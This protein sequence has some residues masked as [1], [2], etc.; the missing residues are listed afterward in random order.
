[1]STT[2]LCCFSF[3][4]IVTAI[5]QDHSENTTQLNWDFLDG[6]DD[7]E[8]RKN[9]A[10]D[11]DNGG[12]AVSSGQGGGDVGSNNLTKYL[13]PNPSQSKS[14]PDSNSNGTAATSS[15]GREDGSPTF[16]LDAADDNTSSPAPHQSATPSPTTL[17]NYQTTPS[18]PSHFTTTP[19]AYSGQHPTPVVA[20][21]FPNHPNITQIPPNQHTPPFPVRHNIPPVAADGFMQYS[22]STTGGHY[23]GDQLPSGYY[24]NPANHNMAPHFAPRNFPYGL[25]S[26]RSTTPPSFDSLPHARSP[27]IISADLAPP[28]A[29]SSIT[30]NLSSASPSIIPSDAGS[31]TFQM[32]DLRLEVPPLPSPGSRL[33]EQATCS[34]QTQGKP[35]TLT[36]MLGATI[37]GFAPE[38]IPMN[39][40]R[41]SASSSSSN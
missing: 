26:P 4:D 16:L 27:S 29:S 36:P 21:P 34:Q 17:P 7:D 2:I 31:I 9:E 41:N 18:N 32:Q 28:H 20:T 33:E 15:A 25:F 1:M 5:Q 19:P 38:T 13:I 37:N 22:P 12:E 40:I 6:V 3:N 30:T 23:H 11:A 39:V 14:Y 24:T 10:E 8:E 35:W